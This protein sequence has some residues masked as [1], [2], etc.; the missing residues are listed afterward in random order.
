M[1]KT[2]KTTTSIAAADN[3][4]V[5]CSPGVARGILAKQHSC[6]LISHGSGGKISPYTVWFK[7]GFAEGN[8]NVERKKTKKQTNKTYDSKK[9]PLQGFEKPWHFSKQMKKENIP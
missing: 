7:I 9:K 8:H 1:D 6:I 4:K 2:E 3:S 5:A